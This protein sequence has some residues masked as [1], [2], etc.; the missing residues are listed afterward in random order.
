MSASIDDWPE[1]VGKQPAAT[2]ECPPETAPE[3]LLE[4]R[5]MGVC[6]VESVCLIQFH[7]EVLSSTPLQVHTLRGLSVFMPTLSRKKE[8]QPWLG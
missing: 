3:E 5:Q 4:G 8:W 1:E 6:L 7:Y 2:D